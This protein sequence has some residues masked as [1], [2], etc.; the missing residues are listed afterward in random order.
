MTFARAFAP[1]TVANV[2]VGFDILG[3]AVQGAGDTVEVEMRAEPGVVIE[4]IVGDGGRLPLDPEKNTAA[5]AANAVLKQIGAGQGVIIRLHKGLPLNSGLGSSA[6]SGVA[7]AVAVNALFGSLLPKV[8][9]LS[10]CLEGEARVSGYHA[11]NAGPSLL[12]G[13]TLIT[14]TDITQ[15][16]HLPVPEDLELAL[17]T[18]AV[19]VPT[20]QARAVLPKSISLHQMVEQTAA[21]ARLVDALYRGDIAAMGAAM[22]QDRVVEPARAHLM[23][24]LGEVRIAAK[25]AGACGLVISGAGPTL[26][27]ICNSPH[28]AAR[29]AQ[30]M[31][32]VYDEQGIVS[33]VQHTRVDR[34]GAQVELLEA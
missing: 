1:A 2:G 28:I 13:I 11:D 22:E 20:A 17:V 16:Y 18:P 12:G 30:R 4:S 10:A 33:S 29:V 6:A 14:G 7:A 8:A 34:Y 3:M 23:P 26:C 24:F 19:D 15:I 27:A 25:E 21:V 32:E 31:K 9:L 5:V